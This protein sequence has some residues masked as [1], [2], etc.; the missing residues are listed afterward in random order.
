[1]KKSKPTKLNVAYKSP[2]PVITGLSKAECLR[3]C[4]VIVNKK[5]DVFKSDVTRV[6]AN[7]TDINDLIQMHK[8]CL[9]SDVGDCEHIRKTFNAQHLDENG[10]RQ[11]GIDEL[12]AERHLYAKNKYD[13]FCMPTNVSPN[14][15]LRTITTNGVDG[16]GI[17]TEFVET[18]IEIYGEDTAFDA[19][20]ASIFPIHCVDNA[21][22]KKFVLSGRLTTHC[23]LTIIL[24]SCF[25]NRLQ[26]FITDKIDMAPVLD[27][28]KSKL[29]EFVDS[30]S[31]ISDPLFIGSDENIDTEVVRSYNLHRSYSHHGIS[32]MRQILN[33]YK[34]DKEHL[35][36][37]F[38]YHKN[39]EISY[40]NIRQNGIYT[41]IAF[42]ESIRN[43]YT[44]YSDYAIPF[45]ESI[46]RVISEQT[47]AKIIKSNLYR[48]SED[49]L[50]QMKIYSAP[51][52]HDKL[53][54]HANPY[55]PRDIVNNTIRIGGKDIEEIFLNFAHKILARNQLLLVRA[56]KTLPFYLSA[57]DKNGN[58]RMK[59]VFDIRDDIMC[60]YD[61]FP[62]SNREHIV[63]ESGHKFVFEVD[64]NVFNYEVTYELDE[65]YSDEDR[66]HLHSTP[67]SLKSNIF[68]LDYIAPVKESDAV[69]SE[70]LFYAVP[71]VAKYGRKA[72]PELNDDS[73]YN[74]LL[75]LSMLYNVP[76][77]TKEEYSDFIGAFL[78]EDEPATENI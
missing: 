23:A 44:I 47:F 6:L 14:I 17:L 78:K 7:G 40:F 46:E 49:S 31:D 34:T 21:L 60:M 57:T 62:Y 71:L 33:I 22:F 58:R 24:N 10:N 4:G 50:H 43:Y 52:T 76:F 38:P 59:Y 8:L 41:A 13:V 72:F 32:P 15:D 70:I 42:A 12:Y 30:L 11:F 35:Y 73:Y 48:T 61:L 54:Y 3:K 16:S 69:V 2:L 74:T 26:K 64:Q 5:L 1:M 68:Q 27:A 56:T 53:V 18:L 45:A 19:I 39:G 63:G 51:Q 29:E 75:A 65:D 67:V 25:D 55:H 36:T 9:L 37:K 28:I 20:Q 66:M 77:L